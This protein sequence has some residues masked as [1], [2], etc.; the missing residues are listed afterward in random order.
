MVMVSDC[1]LVL[2]F[3]DVMMGISMV[4]VIYLLIVFLNRVIILEV[5]IVVVRLISS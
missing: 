2:L 5:R 1:V 3:I 4:R